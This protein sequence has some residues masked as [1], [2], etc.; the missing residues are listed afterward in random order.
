M[1][2]IIVGGGKTGAT[3]AASLSDEGHDITMIDTD[4]NRLQHIC[5]KNDVLGINGNGMN[6]ASLIDAGIE[7]A[8]ILI[9]VTGSDEQNL[10]CCLFAKK[11]GHCSTIARVRNPMYITENNFIK[12]QIGLSMIINPELAAANEISRLLRFPSAIEINTFAKGRLEQL[13]F[14]IPLNSVLDG[15]NLTYVRSKIENN[16]LFCSVERNGEFFIPSGSFELK[17]GD[18]A[19]IVISPKGARKFF[20]RIGIDTHGVKNAMIVGGGTIAYYLSKQL[21]ADGVAVKIIEIDKDKCQDLA[22]KLPDALIINEDASDKDML[23]E[24]GIEST[25]A[26]VALSGLDEENVLLSLYAKQMSKAKV[27]T[28]INRIAFD[29]VITKLDLDSVIYPRNITSE[30]VLQYV[31][32]KQNAVGNNVENLYRL[33][34]DKVEALE[35]KINENAPIIG[36][37]L[38][39]MPLKDNLLICGINRAG[40]IIIPNGEDTIQAGDTVIV[41]TGHK[42]LNDVGDILRYI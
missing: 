31:R 1:K 23:L 40:K 16:L 42:K 22:E 14:R 12:E 27:V 33:N 25:Q 30:Y 19:S 13:T 10:L 8:D 41:V 34:D 32:A 5:M 37:P 36:I 11:T 39:K 4:A 28:K 21:S 2:I 29:S 18:K 20:K 3:I 9:A 26:F 35:F 17:S 15:K 24:E 7:S 38:Q 6:Y